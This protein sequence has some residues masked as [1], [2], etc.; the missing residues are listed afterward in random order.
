MLT[1]PI[2]WALDSHRISQQTKGWVKPWGNCESCPKWS[3]WIQYWEIYRLAKVYGIPPKKK[4]IRTD[5]AYGLHEKASK[6]NSQEYTFLPLKKPTAAAKKITL[7]IQLCFWQ[8]SGHRRGF[9]H[10]KNVIFI[11]TVQNNL[12]QS[13]Y[14]RLNKAPFTVPS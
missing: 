11:P 1:A 14:G 3:H 10:F 5:S 2:F 12:K 4:K 13:K 6:N 9:I 7:V 8:R